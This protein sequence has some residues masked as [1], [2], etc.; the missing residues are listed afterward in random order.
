MPFVVTPL[1]PTLLTQW[2]ISDLKVELIFTGLYAHGA[3]LRQKLEK[4]EWHAV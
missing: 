4:V 3:V 2:L 1:F